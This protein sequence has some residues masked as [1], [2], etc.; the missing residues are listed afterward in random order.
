MLEQVASLSSRF[1]LSFI[2]EEEEELDDFPFNL[3]D[4]VTV[5]EVGD[6]TDLPSAQSPSVPMETTEEDA[7][8]SV[9][10]DAEGVH[11]SR[12]HVSLHCCRDD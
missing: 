12:N 7:P 4:F 9:Q 10:E 5:D 3:S 11:C 8:T 1:V 6:V 2:Q